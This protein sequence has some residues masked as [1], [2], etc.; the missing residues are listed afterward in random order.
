V[1]IVIGKLVRGR[2][3]YWSHERGFGFIAR[4]DRK[5]NNVFIHAVAFPENTLPQLGDQIEFEIQMSYRDGR[6]RAA[7][8]SIVE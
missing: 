5:E 2:L 3:V 6:E 7:N 8:A 4:D 1:Q